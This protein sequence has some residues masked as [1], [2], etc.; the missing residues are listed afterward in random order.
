MCI[1]PL[2]NA[3]DM[4]VATNM[5]NPKTEGRFATEHRCK[6]LQRN[7][8]ADVRTPLRFRERARWDLNP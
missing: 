3:S 2:Q 1:L 5:L 7:V 6:I 8:V 4:F